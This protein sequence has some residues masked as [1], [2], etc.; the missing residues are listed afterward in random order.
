LAIC[1]APLGLWGIGLWFMEQGLRWIL[2][3]ARTVAA[4]DGALS[5]VWAPDP[6]VLPV[7]SLA[8]LWLVLIKGQG[9]IAG[10]LGV[11]LAMVMWM[12]STRPAVLVADSGS[13]IG[14]QT[15]AGRALS[16]PTG[17]GFVA[18]IW[19][20]N[21]GMPVA[22]ADAASRAGIQSADRLSRVDLGGW[23]ILQ[24]SGKT[25]LAKLDGC[26]GADVLISNRVI[27][28]A[29]S[30]EVFDLARLRRTGALSFDLDGQGNLQIETAHHVAGDRP[31]NRNQ[32]GSQ[33]MIVLQAPQRQRA[34]AATLASSF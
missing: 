8:L 11:I 25:A 3:V 29:L 26:G 21:D 18:G 4:K 9:R 6:S 1:L 16:K 17:A 15:P 28:G 20:E 30:C 13:L 2:Y 12:Q 33:G 34:A 19:L 7:L 22:Q 31:W 5:H 32:G 24:V 10:A 14:V 23:T 27:T